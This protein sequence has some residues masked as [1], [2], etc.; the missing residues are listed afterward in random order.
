VPA[1]F[2]TVDGARERKKKIEGI[3]PGK[4][5]RQTRTKGAHVVEMD[6]KTHWVPRGEISRRDAEGS[7]QKSFRGENQNNGGKGAEKGSP[8]RIGGG[9]TLDR[10]QKHKKKKES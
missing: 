10:L 9:G 4:R 8:S 5:L 2:G 3:K 7:G 1:A 6:S